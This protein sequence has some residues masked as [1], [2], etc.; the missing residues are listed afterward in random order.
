MRLRILTFIT[1]AMLLTVGLLTTSLKEQERSLD[2]ITYSMQRVQETL[3][4][5]TSD[6]INY[7]NPYSN[8]FTMTDFMFNTLHGVLYSIFVELNTMLGISVVW[9]YNN[10]EFMQMK[11][12]IK[13]ILFL[14]IAWIFSKSAI[15]IGTVYVFYEDLF[16]QKKKKIKKYW[17]LLLA[18]L[19]WLIILGIIAL[20]LFL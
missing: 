9:F 17:I 6:E 4:N 7:R 14:G 10:V 11:F 8:N 5:L 1:I 12:I 20:I 15:P 2:N 18:I 13:L 16:E 19:T 3:F